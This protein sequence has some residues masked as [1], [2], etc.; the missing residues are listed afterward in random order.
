MKQVDVLKERLEL[1]KRYEPDSEEIVELENQIKLSKKAKSSR[2]KG[3]SYESKVRKLLGERFPDLDFSRVPSSGGFQKSSANTLLRGDLVNLNE[4]YDFKLHLE[5]KNQNRWQVNTWFEQA[6]SDCI[7]GKLPI[8]IMH[9]TQKNENGKRIAEADDF[10]FL[11]LK[12]F[13]DILDDGKIIKKCLDKKT[14]M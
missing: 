13:L 12:D 8:V 6:E 3:A 9:R 11:R 7:E 4:D 5:L 14:K 1:L 2:G 10:V